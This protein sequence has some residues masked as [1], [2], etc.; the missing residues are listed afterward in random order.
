MSLL[1]GLNGVVGNIPDLT[2]SFII[3]HPTIAQ[4]T[5]SIAGM[6]GDH[7]LI[8]PLSQHNVKKTLFI[9]A[10]GHGDAVRFQRLAKQLGEQCCVYMLQPP[11]SKCSGQQIL[12][13][14]E[15][16]S[17]YAELIEQ[18]NI[19]DFYIAGFSIGGVAALETAR[20]LEDKGLA[21]C[22]LLLLD[23]TFPRH[24]YYRL[25]TWRIFTALSKSFH[26]LNFKLNDRR[27]GAMFA[28]QGLITHISSLKRY[29]FTSYQGPVDLI[30]S[31]GMAQFSL[32]LFRPWQT[33]LV[34]KLDKVTTPGM[35]GSMF[36]PQHIKALTDNILQSLST[37]KGN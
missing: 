6:I 7:P 30:M 20:V 33:F 26:L 18:E 3:N 25:G 10:S 8:V 16:A 4:Q 27:I 9:I 19:K 14:Q 36:M 17:Q 5:N 11:F 23:T 35:H 15:L 32:I 24:F 12:S 34:D 29:R 21:P 1:V 13:I 22:K 28:D 37:Q 31:S 2:L